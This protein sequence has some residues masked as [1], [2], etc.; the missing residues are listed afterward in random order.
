MQLSL[1]LRRANDKLLNAWQQ[2]Y[3]TIF[4]LNE[5][6]LLDNSIFEYTIEDQ[7]LYL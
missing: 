7:F 1:S 2:G 3:R 5:Y 6:E 4:M